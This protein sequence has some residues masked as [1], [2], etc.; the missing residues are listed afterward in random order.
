M[1]GLKVKIP[2][3]KVLI[4]FKVRGANYRTKDYKWED[5]WVVSANYKMYAGYCYWL[6]KIK[7][8]RKSRRGNNLYITVSDE[9]ITKK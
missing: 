4:G 9:N 5:G 6:Y 2:Q 3:P 7:L 8:D 1:E